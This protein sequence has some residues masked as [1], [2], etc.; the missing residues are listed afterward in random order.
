MQQHV[1]TDA[2]M[3]GNVE[4]HPEDITDPVPDPPMETKTDTNNMMVG[5]LEI[6]SPVHIAYQESKLELEPDPL[7]DKLYFLEM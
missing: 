7:F 6:S 4:T 1:E 2:T 5:N 3:L